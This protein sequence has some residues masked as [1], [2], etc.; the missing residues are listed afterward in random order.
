MFMG[1]HNSENLSPHLP[2]HRLTKAE[3]INLEAHLP[4]L[5]KYETIWPNATD[6]NPIRQEHKH[7]RSNLVIGVPGMWEKWKGSWA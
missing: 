1:I 6:H 2:A 7:G 5:I 3:T 4:S